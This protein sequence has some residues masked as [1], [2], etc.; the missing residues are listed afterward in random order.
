[1]LPGW[2]QEMRCGNYQRSVHATRLCSPLFPGGGR[3]MGRSRHTVALVLS[4]LLALASIAPLVAQS[5]RTPCE[6]APSH[7]GVQPLSG[8]GGRAGDPA[9]GW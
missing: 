3:S 2:A 1:M 7:C 9:A 4:P 8:H 6:G 5:G